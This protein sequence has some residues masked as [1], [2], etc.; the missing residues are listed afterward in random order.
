MG[1]CNE[2]SYDVTARLK[3]PSPQSPLRAYTLSHACRFY[4]W[5]FDMRACQYACMFDFSSYMRDLTNRRVW[6]F[7]AANATPNKKPYL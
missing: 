6:A 2:K 7:M 5:D 3:P 4:F 1:P